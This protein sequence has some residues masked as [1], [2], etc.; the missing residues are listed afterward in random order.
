MN[1]GTIGIYAYITYDLKVIGGLEAQVFHLANELIKRNVD[2]NLIRQ[3]I[4]DIIIKSILSV[5]EK[6]LNAISTKI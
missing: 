1:I 3:K 6:L 5:Q 2:Y 4:K